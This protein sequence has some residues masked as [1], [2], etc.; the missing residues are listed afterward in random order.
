MDSIQVDNLKEDNLQLR[1]VNESL[2]REI[3]RLEMNLKVCKDDQLE[4]EY[5]IEKLMR[6]KAFH[7]KKCFRLGSE[8]WKDIVDHLWEET[9][10]LEAAEQIRD[11]TERKLEMLGEMGDIYGILV[12]AALKMGFKMRD[13][14]KREI[15]K[16]RERFE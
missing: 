7:K 15:A 16:L 2:R 5:V 3:G 8:T 9:E 13:L 4:I 6:S 12:H 11:P 1:S 10:E 14:E